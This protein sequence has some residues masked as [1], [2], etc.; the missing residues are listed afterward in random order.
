MGSQDVLAFVDD[1]GEEVLLD[2]EEAGSLLELTDGLDAATVSACPGCRSRVLA[3]V[4][5][6]DL[7]AEAPP[8]LRAREIMELADDAPTL[9]LY[10]QDL[11]TECTHARWRDPGS[12]EWA[13]ALE[14]V[15]DDPPALR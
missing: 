2:S 10:V 15:L 9:H 1:D 13:E 14:D 11:T 12:T 5:L 3:C 8:H 7:L 6:V 4:A